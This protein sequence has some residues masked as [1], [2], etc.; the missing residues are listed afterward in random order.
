[1]GRD[2][3]L[4]PAGT[5]GGPAL[6]GPGGGRITSQ[7][8][9][10]QDGFGRVLHPGDLIQVQ[11]GGPVFFRVQEIKKVVES[12]V[13]E[14]LME[15][16]VM[17]VLKFRAPR[18]QPQAEFVRVLTAE[19]TGKGQTSPQGDGDDGEQDRVAAALAREQDQE[20]PL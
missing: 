10:I 14:G 15:I 12:G 3:R 19:E 4:N 13:P 1:M 8:A 11:V 20:L 9:E 2:Q 6:F 7:P 5:L 16:V 18:A 17:A